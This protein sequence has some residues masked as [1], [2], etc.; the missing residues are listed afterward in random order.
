MLAAFLVENRIATREQNIQ[1]T[2]TVY[3]PTTPT[4][5]AESTDPSE[6]TEPTQTTA[7]VEQT[8]PDFIITDAAGKTYGILNFKGRPTILCFWNADSKD[9]VKELEIFQELYD[10]YKDQIH[11]L[12]IHRTTE[13]EDKETAQA[14]L[15]TTS[16]TFPVYFDTLQSA[17]TAYQVTQVPTSYFMNGDGILKA[18][19]KGHLD[20]SAL[21]KVME[22]IDLSYTAQ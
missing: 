18:R 2:A 22:A 4:D 20:P 17:A 10:L 9:A 19:S 21:P 7:P 16:Y 13:E 6:S 11:L 5:N 14:F 3:V 15:R 8:A 1:A 12:M